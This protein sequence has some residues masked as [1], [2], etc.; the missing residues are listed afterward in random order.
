MEKPKP[1]AEDAENPAKQCV[2]CGEVK[3]LSDYAVDRRYPG[4]R[5]NRCLAC[6]A[7]VR[8]P[9]VPR[10]AKTDVR[11]RKAAR[12]RQ[13]I[14]L[15]L[16]VFDH[17][18]WACACCGRE[19]ARPEI[20]HMD[21]KGREHRIELFGRDTNG[22]MRFY[23]W[24]IENGFPEGFQTLCGRCNRA[25]GPTDTCPLDHSRAA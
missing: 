21:G 15:K 4:G 1:L 3:P 2:G 13:Y 18:G 17:Y 20:D 8:R 10:S 11:K 25:K 14:Q 12:R 22:G 24:L 23:K 19:T 7:R 16:A 5:R 9:R 6:D